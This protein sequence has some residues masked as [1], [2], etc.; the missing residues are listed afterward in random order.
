MM[1]SMID[2]TLD[3]S[4]LNCNERFQRVEIYNYSPNGGVQGI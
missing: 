2:S 1:L 3:K 4:P